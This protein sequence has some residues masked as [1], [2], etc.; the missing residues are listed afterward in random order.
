CPCCRNSRSLPRSLVS[1]A[2]DSAGNDV[3]VV[4]AESTLGCNCKVCEPGDCGFAR[5]ES[6]VS[7]FSC[8]SLFALDADRVSSR[9]GWKKV[10]HTGAINET[11]VAAKPRKGVISQHR[12]DLSQRR[13]TT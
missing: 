5:S 10:A 12:A 7:E 4:A 2:T 6:M 9:C 8:S 1:F 13:C 3:A 11:K